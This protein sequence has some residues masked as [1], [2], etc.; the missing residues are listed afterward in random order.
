MIGP[1]LRHVAREP[2]DGPGRVASRRNARL[3]AGL[4]ELHMNES[5]MNVLFIMCYEH[6]REIAGC[7]GNSI[8]AT[9]NIDALAAS[10]VVFESA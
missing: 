2:G 4:R 8:V 1:V 10:G 3:W 5:A 7:H 6:N 9:P